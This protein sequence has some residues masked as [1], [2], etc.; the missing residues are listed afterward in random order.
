ML[1]PWFLPN[2]S[3]LLK[4]AQSL[5]SGMKIKFPISESSSIEATSETLMAASVLE[6]TKS[7]NVQIIL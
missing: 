4:K 1:G 7:Q 6:R 2:I 3:Y 5:Q